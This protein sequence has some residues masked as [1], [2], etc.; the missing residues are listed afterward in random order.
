MKRFGRSTS[1]HSALASATVRSASWLIRGSTS[2][3]TR[4]STPSLR[5]VDGPQHV[6]GPA[7]VVGGERAD[8]L[9]DVGAAQGEVADLLVVGR[10]RRTARPGRS[11]GWW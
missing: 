1:H 11:T 8:R 3:D 10:A 2:I 4:P 9:A 6:A 7:D 5:V